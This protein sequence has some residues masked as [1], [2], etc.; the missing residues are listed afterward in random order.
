[1]IK[2][3]KTDFVRGL[4]KNHKLAQH[5][6]SAIAQDEFT[7]SAE[8]GPKLGDDAWHPS[9]DCT[10]KAIDLYHRG[11][12]ALAR[13]EGKPHP[14]S[15]KKTFQVGH[16]WHAYIQY[17]VVEKLGFCGWDAIEVKGQ[18]R[19][20]PGPFRWAT[21]SADI[22]PC[23]LPVHGDYLIDIKTMGSFDFKQMSLPAWC[24]PKYEAQVNIYMDWF[25]LERAIILCV[26]KD[27]PHD[28]KEYEYVRNQPLIDAIY[29]KW[30]FVGDCIAAGEEPEDREE[31][32]PFVGPKL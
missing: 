6:D 26:S 21:G 5:I 7:W 18:R 9:G 31:I 23:K 32:L 8:F 24:A 22:A 19:W 29:E 28:F 17:I 4:V 14:V 27:S 10:P 25:D 13:L 15:L 12:N 1:V 3:K 20:D 11:V 16:F 30:K 2:L